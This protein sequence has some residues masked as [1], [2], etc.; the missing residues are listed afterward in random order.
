[1]SS[2][3]VPYND[4]KG[5]QKQQSIPVSCERFVPSDESVA[6]R[7]PHAISN[8]YTDLFPPFSSVHSQLDIDGIFHQYLPPP[9]IGLTLAEVYFHASTHTSSLRCS[10]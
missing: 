6:P 4:N 7:Q 1:M 3:L 10:R 9:E 8:D 5:S 2:C